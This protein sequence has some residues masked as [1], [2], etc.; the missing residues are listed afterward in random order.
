MTNVISA[1]A[2]GRPKFAVLHP[3]MHVSRKETDMKRT[4]L[5]VGL[6]AALAI[7]TA[8]VAAG[9]RSTHK[10][11]S[12]SVAKT[13]KT[14]AKGSAPRS[15][16]AVTMRPSKNVPASAKTKAH[17]KPKAGTRS[18]RKPK[19]AASAGTASTS[20]KARRNKSAG[21]P[22]VGT[23]LNQRGGSAASGKQWIG[24]IALPISI[25]GAGV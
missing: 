7:P 21:T 15:G 22:A 9:H 20:V 6:V 1:R 18:S 8:A 25:S 14:K 5:I 11:K 16:L 19:T 24:G 12:G 4:L 17:A 10:A 3:P 13:P 2:T 23:T